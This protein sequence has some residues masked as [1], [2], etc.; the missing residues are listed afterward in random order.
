MLDL[1]DP[2]L[3]RGRGAAGPQPRGRR[4]P[5]QDRR[6]ARD[7]PRLPASPGGGPRRG[8]ASSTESIHAGGSA[9]RRRGAGPPQGQE[10]E[11]AVLFADLRGFSLLA[12][13]RLPYDVVFVLNRYF[14]AMGRAIEAAGGHVDKFIGDGVMALFGVGGNVADGARQALDAARRM[15]LALAELNESLST[16]IGQRLR[17]GIG[18]HA[19]PAI[20]GEMGY[21]RATGLTAIGDTVNVASRIEALC[22]PYGAELVVSDSAAEAAG[23]GRDGIRLESTAIRGRASMIDVL[24]FPRVGGPASAGL[25]AHQFQGLDGHFS[26]SRGRR[27]TACVPVAPCPEPAACFATAPPLSPAPRLRPVP[28]V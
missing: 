22:K 4:R 21:G 13:N 23:L 7:A 10:R 24:V 12:E 17:I 9:A 26:R 19:G 2:R 11:I 6:R 15:D 27:G 25:I 14:E 1:Q 20:V 16:E 18:I 5:R 3:E 28:V 8:A